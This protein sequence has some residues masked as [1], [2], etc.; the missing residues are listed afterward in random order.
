MKEASLVLHSLLVY[1]I[2]NNVHFLVLKRAQV[3]HDAL[4]ALQSHLSLFIRKQLN[5]R[6]DF[7][8]CLLQRYNLASTVYLSRKRLRFDVFDS[9]LCTNL[10][11]Y[12]LQFIVLVEDFINMSGCSRHLFD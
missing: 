4:K 11:I 5:D 3:V 1:Q 9:P 7:V 8:L 6:V 10:A 12:V 2:D